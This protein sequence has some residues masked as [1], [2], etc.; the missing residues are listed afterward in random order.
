MADGYQDAELI[1]GYADAI[2]TVARA[3]GVVDR[4]EDELYRLARLIEA[5][6]DL[7]QQLAS[8]G[9]AAGAKLEIAEELLEGRTHPQ[10]VAAVLYV[11]QA[12]RGRQLAQI[13]DAVVTKAAAARSR[14]VAEARTAVALSEE[15][16]RRLAEALRRVL[17]GEV[18]L[19]A[20]VDERVVGGLVVKVGDTVIDGSVARRLEDLRASLTGT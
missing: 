14:V 19:K 7:G 17:G 1:A 6:P 2:L 15:Q 16:E 20:V 11:L 18:E 10:T 4:L 9:T 12:G 3:E 13:A 8:P 5:N